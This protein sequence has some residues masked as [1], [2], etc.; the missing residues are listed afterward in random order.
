MSYEEIAVIAGCPLGTV[1]SRLA[2]AREALRL[3]LLPILE[4]EL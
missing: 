1:R 2:L 3:R 4:N